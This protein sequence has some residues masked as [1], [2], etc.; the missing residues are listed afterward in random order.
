MLTSDGK[1]IARNLFKLLIH[2]ADGVVFEPMST[3]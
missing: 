2:E 3:S 1:I